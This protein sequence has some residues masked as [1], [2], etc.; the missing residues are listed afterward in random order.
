MNSGLRQSRKRKQ[1]TDYDPSQLSSRSFEQLLQALAAKVL[2]PGV[3][4]F[5][6]G[7]DGGREATFHGKVAYP[8]GD[9]NW[10]GYGVLQAKFRQRSGK[11][12]EDGDWAVTQLKSEI[13]KY[14]NSNNNLRNPEYFIYATNVVLT[15]AYEKGSKDRIEAILEDFKGRLPLKGFDI[16]DYDK[17]RVFLDDNYDIR[18]AY[19][20]WITPGDVLAEL[21][22]TLVPKTP[23]FQSILQNFLQ[24]ELLSDEYVNLEQ[25]GH[26]IDERISLAQVF[27]DL[28][29]VDEP[30]RADAFDLE[31][32][33]DNGFEDHAQETPDGGFIK[34]MLA[35]SSERLDPK[36]LAS[37]TI[38]Q[39]PRTSD[40][41]PTRG[42]F[43]LIGGPGQGKTTVGQFICQIF[44]ASIISR[45]PQ[46]LLSAEVNS[47]LSLI[48]NH[49]QEEAIDYS[50]VPRFPFRIVLNEFASALSSESFPHINSVF[51]YIVSQ[52]HKRTGS[53]V[54]IDDMKDWFAHYPSIIVF[55]GL[56]EVPSSSNREQV[57][58]AIRD[59]L[60]RCKQCQ[61][62]HSFNC[63]N[64][65]SRVQ[66][67]L[68]TDSLSTPKACAT[69][70]RTW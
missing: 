18:R 1:L 50:L 12:K 14:F 19:T 28:P 30:L 58:E 26:D 11:V 25:A 21:F 47:A 33:A 51:S 35:V 29:I 15:P 6:D 7:P 56:D 61:C 68:F 57:L 23:H 27:V 48:N 40:S 65:T 20:A 67:R 10:D 9:D 64:Q 17:I 37:E 34:A 24:K 55:D 3:G 54:S 59:F 45:R 70:E 36:S 16:W 2:G 46:H 49:C 66:R 13:K 43:V 52:I 53:T 69:F 38:G 62:R 44:R 22:W 41:S 42:R 8:N 60:D 63:Y 39:R 5:G 32:G 31:D 4:V